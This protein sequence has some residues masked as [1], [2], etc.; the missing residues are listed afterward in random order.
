MSPEADVR[1]RHMRDAARHAVEFLGDRSLDQ[2][3]ADTQLMLALVKCIE[4]IGEAANHLPHETTERMPDV[5]WPQIVNMRHRLVHS[6][7]DINIEILYRTVTDDLPPL[8]DSL[9]DYLGQ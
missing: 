4:I 8:L 6:Y 3:R 9:D 2:L 7:F 5:P 1:I